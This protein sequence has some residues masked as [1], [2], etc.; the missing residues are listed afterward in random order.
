MIVKEFIVPI[1]QRIAGT[2][3]IIDMVQFDTYIFSFTLLPVIIFS[4]SFNMEHH[5]LIFFRLYITQITFFAVVGTMLAITFT[6]VSIA[7]INGALG[8]MLAYELSIA[9]S[10]SFV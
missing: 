3:T 2:H 1:E 5:A 8:P 9:V 10:A 4:S 7:A 6:G